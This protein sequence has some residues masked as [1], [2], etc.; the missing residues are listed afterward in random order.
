[1]DI[2]ARKLNLI[3]EFLRITDEKMIDRIE[4][5]I[6]SEESKQQERDLCPMSLD[7]FHEMIDKSKL[8]KADRR[9]ISHNELKNR[10][11]TW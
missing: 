3:Q 4:S 8:N 6:R 11:K 10:V 9:V 1:M 5:V 7:E 2:Q